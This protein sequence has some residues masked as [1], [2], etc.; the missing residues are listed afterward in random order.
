MLYFNERYLDGEMQIM[1][2]ELNI[3]FSCDEIVK[4]CKKLNCGK[5]AGPDLI[6]NEFLKY[7]I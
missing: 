2:D 7:G 5:S 6:L 4:A 3:P 1:F